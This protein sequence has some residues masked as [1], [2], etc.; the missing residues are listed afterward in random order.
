MSFTFASDFPLKEL[1]IGPYLVFYEDSQAHLEPYFSPQEAKEFVTLLHQAQLSPRQTHS[2]VLSWKKSHPENPLVDNLLC[3]SYLQNKE[4]EPAERLIEESYRK[5]PEYFFSKI[6]YADL[7]LSRKN[8][9]E[10]SR[11]FPSFDLSALYSG[12]TRFHVSE[13]RG[14]M[15]LASRYHLGIGQKKKAKGYYHFAYLA[16]PSHPSL[17][18]LER[19]LFP[20]KNVY[21]NWILLR[22]FFTFLYALPVKA[23]KGVLRIFFSESL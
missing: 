4:V 20:W 14:F 21:K 3:F 19:K 7:C 5:H 2:Q 8:W 22:K 18:F 23:W 9:G 6:N 13:F 16:D 1:S 17:V 11:I 15:L 10:V 12:K